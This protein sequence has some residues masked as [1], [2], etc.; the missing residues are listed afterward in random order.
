MFILISNNSTKSSVVISSANTVSGYIFRNFNFIAEYL[1]LREQNRKLAFENAQYRNSFESSYR[2]NI[3]TKREI[4]DSTYRQQ[5]YFITAKVINNS[6]NR[7]YNYLTLDRGSAAG[8]KED[9]AVITNEGAVGVV[10]EVSENY[11]SVVS[12]LNRKI[13]IS[14]R[15]KSNNYYGL[16]QW[17]GVDYQYVTLNEIP[18]HIPLNLGD[19]IITSGYSAIFPEG[20]PIGIISKYKHDEQSNFYIINV[21]LSSNFKNLQYVYIIGDLLKDERLKLEKSVESYE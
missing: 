2:S 21:K 20:I 10:R 16:I 9:M 1:S 17:D 18:N 5:Y 3:V 15:I 13:G 6:I 12:I 14:A 11:S 4:S 19:T 8:I 7:Q